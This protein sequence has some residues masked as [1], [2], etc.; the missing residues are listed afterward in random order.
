LK[1]IILCPNPYRDQGLKAASKAKSI[2]EKQG[3]ETV[4]CLPFRVEKDLEFPADIHFGNLNREILRA[5]MIICFGGD[6]T[7]LHAAKSASSCSLP[8]LGINMGSV[9]FMA[10]LEQTELQ[11]LE[12]IGTGDYT[13]EPHMMLDARVRRDGKIVF[14]D[15]ALNDAVISKGAVARILDLA[16]YSDGVMMSSF[17]G[18]GL[19]VSTPTG[20]TAYSMA[21]G[22][23]IV[24]P[25]ARNIIVTPLCAHAL[26]AKA[27]VLDSRRKVTVITGP[28]H[29]KTAYLSVDGGHAFRLQMDDEIEIN[30]SEL[31]TK[32]VRIAKRNFYEV[33]NYKLC[34]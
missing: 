8:I 2:L 34:K 7:I 21:A 4:F 27:F 18:D 29:R 25:A 14:S 5:D 12:K 19:I 30:Q 33:L 15:T 16:V 32:L 10:E 31:V 1:K 26:D 6:G 13:I 23:P 24:E 20:S 11:Q 22:G 3:I 9:G 28:L 17:S